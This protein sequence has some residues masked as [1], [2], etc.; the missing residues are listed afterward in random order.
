[1]SWVSVDGSAATVVHPHDD[2][3]GNLLPG[4][5]WGIVATGDVLVGEG[6]G[7]VMWFH[8]RMFFTEMTACLRWSLR[9]QTRR[10]SR[11]S[12]GRDYHL[13]KTASFLPVLGIE[14]S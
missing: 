7:A 12:Q 13:K 10:A 8:Q 6:S 9:V 3:H 1:M 5:L 14:V 4:R 2:G 11:A